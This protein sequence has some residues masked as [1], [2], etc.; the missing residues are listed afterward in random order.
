MSLVALVAAIDP[1]QLVTALGTVIGTTLGG[2]ALF[3]TNRTA[4]AEASTA[5]EVSF[6][7][8][9]LKIMQGTI[10]SQEAENERLRAVVEEYRVKQTEMQ[11]TLD[12]CQ[13]LCVGLQARVIELERHSE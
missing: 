3:L 12:D 13:R 2:L 8:R 11:V 6:V 10:E 4:R 7:D 5:K 1:V 9:N